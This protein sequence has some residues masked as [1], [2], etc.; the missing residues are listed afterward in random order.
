[1][2]DDAGQ[3]IADDTGMP[4]RRELRRVA[5]M[6]P[7]YVDN[8]VMA[9]GARHRFLRKIA[10]H[11]FTPKAINEIEAQVQQIAVELFDAIPSMSR[12]TSSTPSPRRCR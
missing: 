1:M 8:L 11:A 5:G 6:G 4:R 10:S 2:V 12:S 7:L 3:E 9:D